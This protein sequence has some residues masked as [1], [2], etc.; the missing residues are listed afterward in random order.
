MPVE[1]TGSDAVLSDVVAVVEVVSNDVVVVVEIGVARVV[2]ADRVVS[3]DTVVGALAP[4]VVVDRLVVL[5][6]VET[7]VVVADVGGG[8]YPSVR[9]RASSTCSVPVL[10][11]KPKEPSASALLKA[12]DFANAPF[13]VTLTEA[14]LMVTRT[15]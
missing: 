8:V 5:D 11:R 14:P 3:L 2:V 6:V 7:G 9:I 1:V 4:D 12:I 15:V 10:A 13:T